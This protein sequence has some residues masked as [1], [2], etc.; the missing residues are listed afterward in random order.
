VKPKAKPPENWKRLRLKAVI[1][2]ALNESENSYHAVARRIEKANAAA[3]IAATISWRSLRRIVKEPEAAVLKWENLVALDTFFGPRGEGL[4]VQPLLERRG[5]LHS[6]AS[7]KKTVMFLLGA[8]PRPRAKRCDLSPW[9]TRSTAR[10]ARDFTVIN[11]GIPH[12]IADVILDPH[13]DE[14]TLVGE[15]WLDLLADPKISPVAIGS[16]RACLASELMLARMFSIAPFG[17]ADLAKD[18]RAKLPFHF[19]WSPRD[20]RNFRSRFALPARQVPSGSGLSVPAILANR[21]SAFRCGEN[22]YEVPVEGKEWTS[23][24]VIAAQ[25][26]SNGQVWLVISGLTG[27]ATYA[28]AM[29]VNDIADTLPWAAGGNGPVLWVAVEAKVR[30]VRRRRTHGD[31]REVVASKLM[32]DPQEWP[33]RKR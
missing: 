20:G 3:G 6:L 12:D 21:A 19:I 15:P 18:L 27:P 2:N 24:G 22:Y 14:T 17:T 16:P 26:R 30:E 11:P 13:R 5:I 4:D 8:K 1:E 25:R 32:G 9:D 28:A 29:K 31:D 23:Y 33:P 7:P 10:L